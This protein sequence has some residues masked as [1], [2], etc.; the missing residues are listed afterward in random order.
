[1][2][3]PI[4]IIAFVGAL[5]VGACAKNPLGSYDAVC[6]ESPHSADA[7]VEAV[8][9]DDWI[10]LVLDDGKRRTD[11]TGKS[12]APPRLPSHCPVAPRPEKSEP[13]ALGPS[14]TRTKS[15]P[16][17]FGLF[18]TPVE[19]LGSG[20]QT[21]LVA[22]VHT[23]KR[24]LSAVG[25][26]TVE[27]PPESVDVE[28][29]ALRGR[30]LLFVSG[31]RCRKRA[32]SSACERVLKVLLLHQGR[33]SPVELRD[34]SNECRGALEL[35]LSKTDEVRLPS[36]AVRRFRLTSTYQTVKNTLVVQEALVASD[37]P[38][39]GDEDSSRLF[40]SADLTRRFGF[41][42]SYFVYDRESL[43]EGMR[44]VHGDLYKSTLDDTTR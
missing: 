32:S 18:W 44:E 10:R 25:I 36:G 8:P 11:C 26:G 39:D 21:L 19:Q 28:L 14:Q 33:F 1:M 35:A 37:R 41:S 27:L 38:R 16:G 12:L 7:D 34:F 4:P 20:D 29:R 17:G 22:L 31:E 30:D 40:R 3:N 15:L 23:N 2:T 9:V 42:G 6:S 43:W 13:I 24:A 5:T